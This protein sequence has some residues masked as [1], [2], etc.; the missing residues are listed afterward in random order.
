MSGSECKPGSAAIKNRTF[1]ARP[2][3]GCRSAAGAARDTAPVSDDP[4]AVQILPSCCRVF[5]IGHAIHAR[6]G[7]LPE[8]H[9]SARR[10]QPK[11]AEENALGSRFI[12]CN[13]LNNQRRPRSGGLAECLPLSQASVTEDRS[14][15]WAQPTTI[16]SRGA[17]MQS[18]SCSSAFWSVPPVLGKRSGVF[19]S[20]SGGFW[21]VPPV[22]GAFRRRLQRSSTG[23]R[24]DRPSPIIEEPS[25]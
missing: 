23:G 13:P 9:S 22:S 2:P 14:P 1:A 3:S 7:I 16:G 10:H 4:G 17:L 8:I 5:R 12:S 6:T 25:S 11:T 15:G 18:R 19:R 24:E 20:R 21:S